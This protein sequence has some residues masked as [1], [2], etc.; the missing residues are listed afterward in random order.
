ML[1]TLEIKTNK[2]KF[3]EVMASERPFTFRLPHTEKD[4]TLKAEISMLGLLYPITI[5]AINPGQY[6]ILD[7]YRRFDAIAALRQETGGWEDVPAVVYSE[8]QLLTHEKLLILKEKNLAGENAYTVYEKARMLDAFSKR[9]L[10][11]EEMADHTKIPAEEI[12]QLL[13][14]MEAPPLLSNLIIDT[15][16]S[17]E[18]AVTLIARYRQWLTT[19]Y[20]DQADAVARRIAE[21]LKEEKVSRLGW[22]FLL[23]FYW[24]ERPFMAPRVTVPE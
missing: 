3:S 20:K 5:E 19:P 13:F 7:G 12:S 10:S 1:N 2:I 11:I 16:M 8:N 9:G 17:H 18:F 4:S 21:H 24:A 15:G 23:D 6:V 22:R 14:L